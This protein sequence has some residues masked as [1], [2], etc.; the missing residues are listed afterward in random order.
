MPGELQKLR[1]ELL[2]VL[3]GE[4]EGL[5]RELPGGPGGHEELLLLLLVLVLLQLLYGLQ[6]L[7]QH[8]ILLVVRLEQACPDACGCLYQGPG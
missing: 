2:L 3:Y 7:M 1:K 8:R 6:D 5:H 4:L